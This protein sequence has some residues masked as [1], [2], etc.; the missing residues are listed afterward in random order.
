[1]EPY[2]VTMTL[3]GNDE[4]GFSLIRPFIPGGRTDRQNMTAWMA[5]VADATGVNSL[6]AYRFPRQETVFGPSQVS[7]RIDQEPEIS[8]QISLWNQSGSEV[9]R[10]NLL[11]IPVGES[12]LYVQ[13]LYLQ[14]R[15]AAGSLPEMKRVIV[16]SSERVI[17]RP[18]LAEALIALTAESPTVAVPEGPDEPEQPDTSTGEATSIAELAAQAVEAFE[19]GQ[20]ALS[21][22]DWAA[23]GE[24]QAELART[25]ESMA[26]MQGGDGAPSATP[27]ASPV[28]EE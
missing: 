22:G 7:A 17:M 27:V 14:A 23:Y 25:L 20:Q 28:A 8:A 11:V 18:T 4:S 9:L 15:D 24:A 2:Y 1:M 19:R 10:G 16:A 12:V 26:A 21:E 5:G 6:V 3:P 13:P